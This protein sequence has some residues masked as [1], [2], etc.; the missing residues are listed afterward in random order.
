M[1]GSKKAAGVRKSPKPPYRIFGRRPIMRTTA[2]RPRSS[3][4][5][6]N[7]PLC[8][9]R[10]SPVRQARRH[11]AGRRR[12]SAIPELCFPAFR[13]LLNTR[14]PPLIRPCPLRLHTLRKIQPHPPKWDGVLLVVLFFLEETYRT[15]RRGDL[16]AGS[17]H[18]GFFFKA[19]RTWLFPFCTATGFQNPRR[20]G[21]GMPTGMRAHPPQGPLPLRRRWAPARASCYSGI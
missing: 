6:D 3:S 12:A 15:G 18:N 14:V 16:G 1:A 21:E 19:I 9:Y 5:R 8:W 13:R 2:A 10:A 11:H 20:R 7:P 17:V 4:R